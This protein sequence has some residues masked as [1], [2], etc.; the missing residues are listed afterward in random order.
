MELLERFQP[1]VTGQEAEMLSSLHHDQRLENTVNLD[2][3]HEILH[4][5]NLEKV[6]FVL[7]DLMQRDLPDL[8]RVHFGHDPPKAGSFCKIKS[9]PASLSC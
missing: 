9:H 3:F 6:F 2:G 4:V 8:S 1:P 7:V 5:L